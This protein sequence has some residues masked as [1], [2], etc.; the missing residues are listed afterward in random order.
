M[1]PVDLP[2]DSAS[3][4]RVQRNWLQ[5]VRRGLRLACPACGSGPLFGKYLKVLTECRSCGHNLSEYRADDAPHY[6]TILLVG[7]LIVPSV[8]MLEKAAAPPIWAQLAL[9]VPMT[10]AMTLL[11]LPRIKGAVIGAHWAASI[12]G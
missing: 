5:G 7:H 2:A 10:L 12:K 8:L 11:L 9:W 4:P 6:F 3:R 1:V